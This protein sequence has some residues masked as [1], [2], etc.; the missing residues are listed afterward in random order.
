MGVLPP[1][2]A[3]SFPAPITPVLSAAPSHPA[4]RTDLPVTVATSTDAGCRDGAEDGRGPT[5]P[6]LL[7]SWA[8]V[9]GS[10]MGCGMWLLNVESVFS[11]G[12][13]LNRFK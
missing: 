1:A 3:I 7:P 5:H 13:G 10:T 2:K 6:G 12:V 11:R 4:K 9:V 8:R